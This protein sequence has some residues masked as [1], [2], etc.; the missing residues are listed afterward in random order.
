MAQLWC[1]LKAKVCFQVCMN[2]KLK[3]FLPFDVTW[4][5]RSRAGLNSL[6]FTIQTIARA[7]ESLRIRIR[8]VLVFVAVFSSHK[9]MHLSITYHTETFTHSESNVHVSITVGI[10]FLLLRRNSFYQ[11]V[12]STQYY[13]KGLV[14]TVGSSCC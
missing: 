4:A 1:Q 3:L 8:N 12:Y 13:T 6:C 10:T 7:S 11:I 2:R 9:D 14:L 5:K